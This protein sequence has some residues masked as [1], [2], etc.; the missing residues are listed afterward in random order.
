ML[1]LHMGGSREKRKKKGRE[2][3]KGGTHSVFTICVENTTS[4][5]GEKGTEKKGG[6]QK[7]K[8][9]ASPNFP[10]II[11]ASKKK[12]WRKEGG[13]RKANK[14]ENRNGMDLRLQTPHSSPH[15]FC[16]L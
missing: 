7:S 6:R 2:E 5:M 10:V 1:F 13:R 3:K 14:K 11:A 4:E 16:R 12:E 15:L 9:I 8:K